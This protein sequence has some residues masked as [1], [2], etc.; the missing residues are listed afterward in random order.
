[1]REENQ[2]LSEQRA[3]SVAKAIQSNGVKASRISF[4]GKGQ[5]APIDENETEE[6]RSRNRRTEFQ[7]RLN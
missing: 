2:S 4:E 1:V 5:S 6:G 7:I 3:E